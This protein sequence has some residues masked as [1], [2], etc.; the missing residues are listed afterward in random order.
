MKC[1][2]AN[3]VAQSKASV[4]TG[5]PHTKPRIV[6]NHPPGFKAPGPLPPP[7]LASANE[8]VV[9]SIP[10]LNLEA[11]CHLADNLA[12][13]QNVNHC[14]ALENN[15]RDQLA[16]RWAVFPNNDRSHCIRYSS[17]GGGGTYTDLLSCLETEV[18]ARRLHAKS[19]SA[20]NQ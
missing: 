6:N 16:R 1:S 9:E 3:P 4:Q 20:A 10:T 2:I 8:I 14:L 17:A 7:K 13:D 18:D 5:E 19:R 15:A 11:S 12:V